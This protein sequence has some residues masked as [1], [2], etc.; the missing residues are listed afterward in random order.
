MKDFFRRN[1]FWLL[2]IAFLLS[3]LIGI[4]S[5]LMGGNA[6]PLSDL[7]SAVTAPVRNGVSAVADWAGGVSRYVF[8]Y[9]EMEQELQDLEKKVAEEIIDSYG[10]VTVTASEDD[11]TVC[12]VEFSF[13]VAHGLNQ[14]WLTAHI[15]V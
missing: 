15:T 10:E 8:H 11:P 1:G 2:V 14:I 13:A 3:V 7:V 6:D 9:G 4:S 5:A 12:L